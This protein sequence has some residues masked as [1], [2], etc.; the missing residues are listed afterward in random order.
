MA[1]SNYSVKLTALLVIEW[2]LCKME[3]NVFFSQLGKCVLI[4][5]N[6]IPEK[7]SNSPKVTVSKS[8]AHCSII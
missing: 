1:L 2:A 8:V 5:E 4:W 6:G 7:G 3:P